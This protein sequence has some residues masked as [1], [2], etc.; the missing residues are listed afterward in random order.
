MKLRPIIKCQG[1]KHHLTNWIIDYF[2]KDYEKMVYVEPFLGGGSVLLNKEPSVMEI[3]NDSDASIVA[4]MKSVRDEVDEFCK[5]LKK[6]RYTEGVFFGEMARQQAGLDQLEYAYNEFVVRKMSRGGMKKAFTSSKNTSATRENT[7]WK[8]TI[9]SLPKIATRIENVYL[10][11]KNAVEVIAAF[12]SPDTLLYIDPPE[13]PSGTTPLGMD[14]MSTDQHAD[15][16]DLLL[17]FRG[18]VIVSG[19]SSTLYNRGLVGW[20]SFKVKNQDKTK[21]NKT[22]AVWLNY[23]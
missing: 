13:I 21:P 11:N 1:S 5:L 18:K 9:T 2:P 10:L 20:R 4:I 6:T 14:E 22:E 7:S 15:L 16:I 3:A 8:T 23:K 19:Y 12:N 17:R